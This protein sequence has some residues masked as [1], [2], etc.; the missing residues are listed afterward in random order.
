MT[1]FRFLLLLWLAFLFRPFVTLAQ[2]YSDYLGAGHQL[3]ITV[4]SSSTSGESTINGF[5]GSSEIRLGDASRFLAQASFGGT[6][7]EIQDLS[8]QGYSSWLETQ[9]ALPHTRVEPM[10]AGI[11][12]L[13]QQID[14]EG[15]EEDF[16][17]FAQFRQAWFNAG[18]RAEDQLR[19]RVKLA[20]SEIFVVSDVPDE[21]MDTGIGLAHYYDMLGEHAFG[22]FRDLLLDVSLHPVMGFYL[23]HLNN[24]KTDTANNIQPDENY[25]REIM[26]LFSIGLYELN[27][28]GSQKLDANGQPIP[29]YDNEDI[30]EYAKIFTGLSGGA[31]IEPEEYGPTFFGAN[32]EELDHR[33]PMNMFEEM[34]EPGPKYLLRGEV[35][36][37]GQSG[38]QDIE[39]A[40]DNLVN[41][42]N[43]GPFMSRL[44]IQRLVTSNPTPEYI[45]RVA[46]VFHDNGKGTRGDMQAVITAI[47]M[48]DEARR[49]SDRN[50]NLN[51]AMLREPLVRYMHFCRAI[52]LDPLK[53]DWPYFLNDFASIS[54]HTGQAPLNSPTVFNFFLPGYQPNGVISDLDLV[55]PEFQIHTSVTSINYVNEV[56]IWTFDEAAINR[57]DVQGGL[58]EGDNPYEYIQET[59]LGSMPATALMQLAA[60][61]PTLV[62]HLNLLLT[63]GQMSSGSQQIILDA[64]TQIQDIRERLQLALYLFFLSPDYT[65]LN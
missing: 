40:I 3:G 64:I 7:Q 49:C 45:A 51:R 25:A 33:V 16:I 34:H 41:H 14:E 37:A 29:T 4:T 19:Q 12:Q 32:F 8:T 38:L 9:F 54:F 5:P 50:A 63:H 22:N 43:V 56:H 60:D 52:E 27:I 57:A 23:S 61:P 48:D 55:A 15:E 1:S 21:L 10:L 2:V 11:R 46:T 18:L 36:P 42:P 17:W 28:D 31:F 53:E 39:R 24:P 58:N 13:E 35:V 30:D 59:S 26:Q 44:L 65:I 6:W 62:N 47:L 20:L